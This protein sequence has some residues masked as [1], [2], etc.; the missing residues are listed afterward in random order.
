MKNFL[1]ISVLLSYSAVWGQKRVDTLVYPN[2]KV[3]VETDS[4]STRL[5]GGRIM[6]NSF[7]DNW[8][9]SAGA[10]GQV[11][12]GNEDDLK[13]LGKRITA[14][15]EGAVGKWIHPVFGLRA[16]L[17]GGV[18]KGYSTG[19]LPSIGHSLIVGNPDADGI[20]TQRWHHLYIEGDVLVDLGN[21]IGGYKQDRLYSPIV[22]IGAGAAFVQ[23]QPKHD[24]D[25]SAMFT[26]GVINKFRL[27]KQFDANLEIKNA[28]VDHTYDREE[29]QKNYE[30]FL[31]VTAGITYHFGQGNNWGFNKGAG[32]QV[33]VQRTVTHIPTIPV[34]EKITDT[35]IRQETVREVTV[36]RKLVLTHPM[37]IFFELDK[38]DISDRA[39]VNLAFVADIIKS[40]KGAKFR[41]IGSADKKTATPAHNQALSVRR[42][43]AVRDYLVKVLVVDPDQLIIDPIGGI[44]RFKPAMVNRA[45]IISQE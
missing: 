40:G 19:K 17:G 45:V 30:S 27:T 26:F 33:V 34:R 44:D 22:F 18:V 11:F 16:K 1:L 15:Y 36:E 23:N 37:A 32:A 42:C 10:G 5:P 21:A 41:L 6:F 8:F 35:V 3:I 12:F 4:T 25:R 14:T 20:Y 28:M 24:G 7:W 38:A 9:V 31:A 2:E 39:K 29:S 43:N 13:P